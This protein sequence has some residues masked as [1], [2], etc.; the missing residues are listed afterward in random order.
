[1]ESRVSFEE[2]TRESPFD[3][4][5]ERVTSL[6]RTKD[7]GKW[8]QNVPMTADDRAQSIKARAFVVLALLSEMVQ[9]V[10]AV[11][12]CND[13]MRVLMTECD[14]TVHLQA[15]QIEEEV[16]KLEQKGILSR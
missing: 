5:Q 8:T 16:Q 6:L 14:G 9:L 13:V 1:M 11:P 2:L 3:V 4:W 7:L 10:S 15:V 12:F